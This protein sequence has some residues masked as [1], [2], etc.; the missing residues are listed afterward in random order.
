MNTRLAYLYQKYTDETCSAEEREEL[1]SIIAANHD[2]PQIADLMDGTWNNIN[3]SKLIPFKNTETVLS[4]I[5]PEKKDNLVKKTNWYRYSAAAAIFMLLSATIYFYTTQNPSPNHNTAIVN[6]I[7][8]GSNK[9]TLTLADGKVIQLDNVAEG[10][11]AQQAGITIRKTKNGQLI[12]D[13]SEGA[14][15]AGTEKTAYNTITTPRGGQYQVNLPDGTKIWLNAASTLKYP[16]AFNDQKRSVELSGEAYF[17]VAKITKP[18]LQGK[19][20]IPFIVRTDKQE[21]EVL[22]THFNVNCYED[23]NTTKT[24]LLEGAVRIAPLNARRI[25]SAN[26]KPIILQPGQQSVLRGNELSVH[27]TD[28]EETVAWKNGYFQFNE[29]DLT[30]IMRQLSRWYNVDV[31]FEGKSPNDLFHFKIPRNLSLQEVLKIF[32]SNG[33]NFKTEGRTLI[34]KS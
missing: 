33:I 11:I 10:K 31:V 18:S 28:T 5:L 8:P 22:G 7:A 21:I 29:S 26:T 27:L 3:N 15:G 23:E 19:T 4:N 13:L 12:Y 25:V 17:E 34:V 1:L 24:T 14:K 16:T 30:S 6:H 20:R 2:D 32:E 9:A